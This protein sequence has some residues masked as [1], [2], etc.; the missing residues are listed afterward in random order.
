MASDNRD[1]RD[2]AADLQRQL[3]EVAAGTSNL[4]ED[5]QEMVSLR[6]AALAKYAA[7]TMTDN[8][9]RKRRARLRNVDDDTDSL[10]SEYEGILLLLPS[11]LY[12]L[13]SPYDCCV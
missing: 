3:E 1:R 5:Q 12:L 9:L 2:Q 7:Q 8:V 6:Y 13:G 11:Q 10:L 4:S